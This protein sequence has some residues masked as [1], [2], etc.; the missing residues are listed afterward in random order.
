MAPTNQN[1]FIRHTVPTVRKWTE[2]AIDWLAIALFSVLFIF[3]MVQVFWRWVLNNPV[4]WTE[5]A[6]NIIYVWVCYLGWAI[7]ERKDTHIRITAIINKF[8]KSVQ[9]YV[10]ILNHLLCILFCILMVYYGIKMTE[11]GA[12]R[13]TVSF[14][15]SYSIVYVIGPISNL[16]ILVYEITQLIEVFTKGPR[17][18]SDEKLGLEEE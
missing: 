10:Q 14:T 17:D 15:M 4:T 3:G 11:I 12:K 2:N 6:I 13:T 8:P 18:Y 16:I 5:E 1:V 9:K 7:A